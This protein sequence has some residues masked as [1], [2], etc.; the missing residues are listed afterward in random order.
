MGK[1]RIDHNGLT[2]PP[3]LSFF[4][5]SK[6]SKNKTQT[7]Q[8]LSLIYCINGILLPPGLRDTHASPD[9]ASLLSLG[10][11]TFQGWGKLG[12]QLYIVKQD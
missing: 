10:F 11:L 7:F 2:I 4:H 8:F 6:F 3:C 12:T 1:K 5:I 9:T